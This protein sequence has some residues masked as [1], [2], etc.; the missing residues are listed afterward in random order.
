[1]HI[2]LKKKYSIKLYKIKKQNFKNKLIRRYFY[3]K[4]VNL[5]IF[6]LLLLLLLKSK[7]DRNRVRVSSFVV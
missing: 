2:N 3:L 6:L 1:M 4:I 7:R 5:Y